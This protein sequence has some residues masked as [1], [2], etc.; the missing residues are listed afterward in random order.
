MN[1]T[2]SAVHR[3]PEAPDVAHYHCAGR[4]DGVQ[5]LG[6]LAAAWGHESCTETSRASG[7]TRQARER[8]LLV[9][10]LQADGKWLLARETF[11]P[12][13]LVLRGSAHG[14]IQA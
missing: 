2:G 10:E 3:E 7:V 4:Y 6:N 14:D 8:W 5:E 1:V 9:F 13:A 11:E 12:V